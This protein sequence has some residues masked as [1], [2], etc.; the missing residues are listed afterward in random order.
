MLK[1]I[2]WIGILA[3]MA[4]WVCD[5]FHGLGS[6]EFMTNSRMDILYVIVL[7]SCLEIIDLKRRK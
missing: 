5:W 3:G 2:L 6:K 1:F 7:I 4:C